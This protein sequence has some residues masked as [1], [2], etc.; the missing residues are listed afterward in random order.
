MHHIRIFDKSGPPFTYIHH[1]TDDPL[2]D[3]PG[4]HLELPSGEDVKFKSQDGDL[5]ITF[6][7]SSPFVSGNTRLTARRGRL[8]AVETTKTIAKI[9]EVFPYTAT[10]GSHSHDPDII[11]DDGGGGGGTGQKKVT[12]KKKPKKKAKKTAKR[13]K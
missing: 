8:T 3:G 2:N 10:V 5:T 12:G 1:N 4:E 7:G 6:K 13:K 9:R 11:I